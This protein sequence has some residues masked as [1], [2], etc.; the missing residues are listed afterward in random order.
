MRSTRQRESAGLAC[1]QAPTRFYVGHGWKGVTRTRLE[2]CK[3]L[4]RLSAEL[5]PFNLREWRFRLQ[6]SGWACDVECWGLQRAD[7]T[8]PFFMP[9][10][11]PNPWRFRQHQSWS[12]CSGWFHYLKLHH[13]LTS[14]F[15]YK[16]FLLFKNCAHTMYLYTHNILF[17]Y[18]KTHTLL[19]TLFFLVL[20]LRNLSV[21]AVWDTCVHCWSLQPHS[22]SI[23]NTPW[24]K[25]SGRPMEASNRW[26]WKWWEKERATYSSS[27]FQS[28]LIHH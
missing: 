23:D 15:I 5:S 27:Y 14:L 1:S 19:H 8:K 3:Q 10:P 21:S 16:S 25:N 20:Y 11:K 13:L 22:H 18:T 24:I 28:F 26:H 9:F 6:R 7:G 12:K 4:P 2:I 17:L